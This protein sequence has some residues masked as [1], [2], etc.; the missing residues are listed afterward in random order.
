MP[1][2]YYCCLR[3]ITTRR[4]PRYLYCLRWYA[5]LSLSC[6]LVLFCR[7]PP[8]GKWLVWLVSKQW[9]TIS[10]EKWRPACD[11]CCLRSSR[12]TGSL[13]E[14]NTWSRQLRNLNIS[15]LQFSSGKAFSDQCS[16]GINGRKELFSAATTVTTSA[17]TPRCVPLSLQHET[18]VR[19]FLFSFLRS[20]YLRGWQV[21]IQ[22]LCYTRQ[23]EKDD[24]TGCPFYLCRWPN[25][26]E[27]ETI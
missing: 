20:R 22:C 23:R 5:C 16:F 24:Y 11:E 9:D 17:M 10:L 6:C 27:R 15:C 26:T 21:S 13:S 3:E 7:T 1:F 14:V 19:P 8:I 4:Y 12:R 25:I 2:G 18:R